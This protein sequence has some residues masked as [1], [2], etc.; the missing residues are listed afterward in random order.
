MAHCNYFAP[1][2]LS[3]HDAKGALFFGIINQRS[4]THMRNSVQELIIQ[5]Q[6]CISIFK[7][8]RGVV[9]AISKSKYPKSFI[10]LLEFTG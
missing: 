9:E 1:H 7:K 6:T 10:F 5:V 2:Q 8:L 3:L 4:D